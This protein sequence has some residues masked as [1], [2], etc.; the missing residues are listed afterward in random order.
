MTAAN[1]YHRTISFS[2]SP[3]FELSFLIDQRVLHWMLSLLGFTTLQSDLLPFDPISYLSTESSLT[4]SSSP[5]NSLSFHLRT[6][7]MIWDSI[8]LDSSAFFT[9]LTIHIADKITEFLT[10][11]PERSENL[12]KSHSSSHLKSN[13]QTSNIKVPSITL[14]KVPLIQTTPGS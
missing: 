11:A 9:N 14:T 6:F 2:I 1:Q 5:F 12:K 13:Q 3:L 4:F 7:C 8:W 10:K